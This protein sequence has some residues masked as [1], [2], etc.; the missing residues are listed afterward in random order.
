M[1]TLSEH[2]SWLE[3][4]TGDGIISSNHKDKLMRLDAESH[5]DG[6]SSGSL[7]GLFFRRSRPALHSESGLPPQSARS[8]LDVFSPMF[9]I[10]KVEE[11]QI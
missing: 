3:S 7:P 5:P 4:L 2:I 10:F 9:E 11:R 8:P 6:T 1:K